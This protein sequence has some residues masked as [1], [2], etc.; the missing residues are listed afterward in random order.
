MNR[1]DRRADDEKACDF[2]QTNTSLP[3]LSHSLIL[4]ANTM[5]TCVNS[6]ESRLVVRPPLRSPFPLMYDPI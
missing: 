1:V 6:F 3:A 2:S 4:A 5:N